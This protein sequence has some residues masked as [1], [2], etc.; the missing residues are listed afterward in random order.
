VDNLTVL[1]QFTLHP[2]VAVEYTNSENSQGAWWN[3][4]LQPM[5]GAP[6]NGAPLINALELFSPI[7]VNPTLTVSSDGELSR[8]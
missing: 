2:F 1:P 3:L 7:P 8:F 6:V 4:T 5:N